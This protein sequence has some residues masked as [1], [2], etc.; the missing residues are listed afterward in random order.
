MRII[1]SVAERKRV[2]IPLP[3]LFFGEI[4]R[5]LVF[6]TPRTSS[7]YVVHRFAKKLNLENYNELYDTSIGVGDVSTL[8]NTKVYNTNN[9]AIKFMA[10]YFTRNWLD[11][12]TFN[13]N[14]FDYVVFT[15][16]HNIAEHLC[17]WYLMFN[18]VNDL[19]KQIRQG[20][21]THASFEERFFTNDVSQLFDI[22]RNYIEY[23][24]ILMKKFVNNHCILTYEMLDKDPSLYVDEI[25]QI[26]NFNFTESD[27]VSK[28]K[29]QEYKDIFTNYDDLYDLIKET[30]IYYDDYTVGT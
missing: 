16:R 25:N 11:F 15:E 14:I 19:S 18:Y 27:F 29:R 4:M 13:W 5:V 21:H 9:Y 24:N 26:S 2:Q 3:L 22:F 6:S 28:K 1:M 20:V 30:N 23:R 10:P 12:N 8:V 17:S 7:S